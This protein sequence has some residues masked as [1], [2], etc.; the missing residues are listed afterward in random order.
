MTKCVHVYSDWKHCFYTSFSGKFRGVRRVCA[1]KNF[2]KIRPKFP[3]KSPRN[4][5]SCTPQNYSVKM[6]VFE[7]WGGV[8]F[9]EIFG[10]FWVSRAHKF[11]RNFCKFRKKLKIF[12]KIFLKNLFCVH[13]YFRLETLFCKECFL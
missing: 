6:R 2:R 4:L 13:L 1:H 9:G 12:K 10:K 7:M 8:I 3:G 5:P 11:F